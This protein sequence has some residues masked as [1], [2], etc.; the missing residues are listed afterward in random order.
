VDLVVSVKF[1]LMLVIV[2]VAPGTP[3]P[4]ASVIVPKILPYTA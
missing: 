3:D 2:T 4:R 1:V